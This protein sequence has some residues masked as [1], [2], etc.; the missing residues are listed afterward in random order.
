MEV[1]PPT[2]FV[3]YWFDMVPG[4]SITAHEN[5]LEVLV[6]SLAVIGQVID[7]EEFVILYADSLPFVQ[8]GNSIQGQMAFMDNISL[9][10]FKDYAREETR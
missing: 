2:S 4:T 8:F 7:E 9:T 5:T 10:E 3:P 1:F 6:Q